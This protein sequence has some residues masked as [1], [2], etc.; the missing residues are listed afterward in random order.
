[1]SLSS[2][3]LFPQDLDDGVS[4]HSGDWLDQDSVS[5]QFSVEFEVESL[6]SEDYS[7]SED[8]HELSDEDDEVGFHG[9]QLFNKI[10][11]AVHSESLEIFAFSFVSLRQNITASG[12]LY[13]HI[14]KSETQALMDILVMVCP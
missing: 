10:G 4:E 1:M 6:D 13:S 11:D 5:D 2:L 3:Y 9:C 12:L 7:L 8:G 14:T